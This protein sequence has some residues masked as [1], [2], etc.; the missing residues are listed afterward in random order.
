MTEQNQSNFVEADIINDT[1][2][3]SDGVRLVTPDELHKIL[4]NRPLDLLVSAID[5]IESNQSKIR[6]LYRSQVFIENEHLNSDL[7]IADGS[8]CELI[9]HIGDE[10][11]EVKGII[12][13]AI[14]QLKKVKS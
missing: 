8:D 7:G 14:E 5:K 4:K 1:S 6:T 2:H 9:Q 11:G 3:N 13:K 12:Q 10:L